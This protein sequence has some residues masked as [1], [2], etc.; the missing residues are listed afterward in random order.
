MLSGCAGLREGGAVDDDMLPAESDLDAARQLPPYAAASFDVL[1][2]GTFTGAFVLNVYPSNMRFTFTGHSA[3]GAAIHGTLNVPPSQAEADIAEGRF[4]YRPSHAWEWVYDN[5]GTLVVITPHGASVQ[6][7]Y[8]V[9]EVAW[10]QD[11][12]GLF[13]ADIVAVADDR[14]DPHERVVLEG[15]DLVAHV[16]GRSVVTCWTVSEGGEL[17]ADPSGRHNDSDCNGF[18]GVGF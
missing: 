7:A 8:T 4:L 1:G 3:T 5:V 6:Q 11:A 18:P 15:E 12:D 2:Y 13:S 16:V 14:L 10:L 17:L 9:R